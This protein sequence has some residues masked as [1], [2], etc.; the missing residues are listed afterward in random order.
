MKTFKLTAVLLILMLFL[1]E[2]GLFAGGTIRVGVL[3]KESLSSWDYDWEA[4]VSTLNRDIK[5]FQFE[6]IEYTWLDLK[7]AIENREVEFVIGSPIFSVE[8]SYEGNLT[9]IATLKRQSEKLRGFEELYGSVIFWHADN[10]EIKN[11]WDIKNR[12]VAAGSPLSIGGWLAAAREFKE[13]GVDLKKSCSSISHFFDSE[14]VVEEVLAGRAD[15]GICRTSALE[16]MSDEGKL[17]LRQLQVSDEFVSH[18]LP[19]LCST[20]LYPEWG[21][22]RVTGT[23]ENLAEK[24]T[25]A[26][27]KMTDE[28]GP[29]ETTWGIPAN[30]SQVQ[31]LMKDL[32]MEPFVSEASIIA[33]SLRTLKRWSRLFI[34]AIL[35]LALTVFFLARLNLRLRRVTSE[36]DEQKNFLKHLI[37]SIP[38]LIFVKSQ[39]GRMIMA[40]QAFA[41]AFGKNADKMV[42]SSESEIFP[43]G[44]PFA[45]GDDR[46]GDSIDTLKFTKRFMLADQTHIYG[47]IIK[48]ACRLSDRGEKR[49]VGIVRDVSAAQRARQ[50]QKQREKL[51]TGIAEAAH[52]VIGAEKSLEEALPEALKEISAA[53]EAQ[54]AGILKIQPDSEN[55]RCFA[56]LYANRNQCLDGVRDIVIQVIRTHRERMMA[57]QVFGRSI[58]DYSA[59]IRQQL[60]AI[61]TYSLLLLPIFVHRRFWGCMVIHSNEHNREW[62][63]HEIAA[64]ELAAEMFGSMI[65]RS[66]DFSRLVDYRDRLRLALD[67]AGL[68]LWE[69]D[70]A[71]GLNLTPDDIYKNL[72]YVIVEHIEE[73]RR[74]GF[75]IIHPD[76]QLLIRNIAQNETCQFE[77][78]L[79]SAS[80]R[81]LWH[82]FIGR[83]YFDAGHRHL[84]LIGFF[85][86]TSS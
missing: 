39:S 42:G 65:E 77:V 47:E 7:K 85:R 69:Y 51:I 78:R 26:L 41:I 73:I 30:Y 75:S 43:D 13:R 25:V 45:E 83:N 76:D 70:F 15:F 22:S 3:H 84:K 24:V 36:L 80:G 35:I 29:L 48:V 18:Q 33:A 86:N 64:L 40:N 4:T 63:Q 52:R 62:Q 56:C 79:R 1:A 82:F 34:S 68:F 66:E 58:Y 28:I 8:A 54:Q 10:R 60:E 5:G 55:F 9:I 2:A 67:S 74:E 20:Q 38:D 71:A 11:L 17:N 72:G 12:R 32:N 57:G 6:L 59:E 61:G 53:V 21:F 37:D 19:F 46:I 27:I 50:I 23:D 16:Q 14:K 44:S 81:Y 31:Q 49:I